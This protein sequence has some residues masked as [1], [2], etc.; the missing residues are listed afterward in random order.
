MNSLEGCSLIL[1]NHSI[2]LFDFS[3]SNGR[4]LVDD[5]KMLHKSKS[6]S[7]NES[8]ARNLVSV[9]YVSI[10]LKILP[11]FSIAYGLISVEEPKRTGNMMRVPVEKT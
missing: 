11:N 6:G 3:G 5:S 4:T 2:V 1:S 10:V 8:P 7:V 9:K